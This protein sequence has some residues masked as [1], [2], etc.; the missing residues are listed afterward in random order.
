[1]VPFEKRSGWSANIYAWLPSMNTPDLSMYFKLV[2]AMSALPT[3]AKRWHPTLFKATAF[4]G[5]E[6]KE[7]GAIGGEQPYTPYGSLRG[8]QP[9][10]FAHA[11]EFA[12]KDGML[13][14]PYNIM[15]FLSK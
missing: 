6:K 7:A 12:T 11:R 2:S 3:P 5:S 14:D 15:G 9:P 10:Y 1:M 8:L 13:I 4:N